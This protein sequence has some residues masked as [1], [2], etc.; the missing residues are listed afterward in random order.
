M[1]EEINSIE[2]NQTWE[3]VLLPPGH[4]LIRLKWVYKLKKNAASEVIKHKA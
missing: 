2:S 3:L 1:L 4:Q